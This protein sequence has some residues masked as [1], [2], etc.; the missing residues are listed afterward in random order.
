MR[1][2]IQKISPLVEVVARNWEWEPRNE[3]ESINII[4]GSLIRTINIPKLALSFVIAHSLQLHQIRMEI[5]LG[6]ELRVIILLKLKCVSQ[7]SN[8]CSQQQQSTAGHR[9]A[10]SH[11]LQLD[12]IRDRIRQ[13]ASCCHRYINIKLIYDQVLEIGNQIIQ[14]SRV[15]LQVNRTNLISWWNFLPGPIRF[16]RFGHADSDYEFSIKNFQQISISSTSVSQFEFIDSP[17]A[18]GT[19]TF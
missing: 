4:K 8:V 14:F 13:K 10:F 2:K 16:C 9:S 18:I 11:L 12:Q 15:E 5:E 6:R 1:C 3:N 7:W 19:G 17:T